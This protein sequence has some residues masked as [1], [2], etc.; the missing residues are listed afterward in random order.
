MTY[1]LLDEAWIP[2]RRASGC[3]DWIAPHD[4]A[5]AEDPPVAIASAR[6]DFD[7]ALLQFL[8]GLLQTASAPKDESSWRKRIKPPPP[9][10]LREEFSAFHAAFDL[11]G[12][13]PRFMQEVSLQAS[14]PTD[15]AVERLLLEVPGEQTVEQNADVFVKRRS[16]GGLS[17]RAASAALIT[18]QLNAPSGG[19]GFRTSLRGG[20][21]LTTILTHDTLWLTA[22]LNVLPD[23]DFQSRGGNPHLEE[24]SARFPWMGSP[25]TSEL[26]EESGPARIHPLQQFWAV[27]R[28]VL[29]Q[30]P[31]DTGFCNLTGVEELLIRRAFVKSYGTNY[32]GAFD[33]PLTPYIETKPGEAPNPKK[34]NTDGLPYRDWPLYTLGR[35]RVHPARVIAHALAQ[36]RLDEVRR[37]TGVAPRLLAFGYSMDNAKAEAWFTAVAP[38]LDL[39]EFDGPFRR[40]TNQ[41]VAVADEVRK[42]LNFCVLDAMKRRSDDVKDKY[43]NS[44][45]S[46]LSRRFWSETEPAF[47]DLVRGLHEAYDRPPDE[48]AIELQLRNWVET[49]RDTARRLFED[50]SQER[51]DFAAADVKRVSEAWNR[52]LAFTSLHNRKIV[53]AAGL[54]VDEDSK[55]SKGARGKA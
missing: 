18:L 26:G 34:L 11:F 14:D 1:N 36:R 49:L 15:L 32:K 5:D 37:A 31:T 30:A 33:H 24:L 7:G 16:D 50:F 4:I 10:T 19:R 52:L 20:G 22:W 21:P 42:V 40:R 27:P 38:V 28:R 54:P 2:V 43:G 13:G 51:G 25:R 8:I 23:S 46:D 29:L 45:S 3:V 55:P 53:E 39:P 17:L 6:P 47:F 48:A 35:E 44:Q 41:A 9:Q 12:D